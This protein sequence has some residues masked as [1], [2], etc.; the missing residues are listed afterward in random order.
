MRKVFAAVLFALTGA[1]FLLSGFALSNL[2]DDYKDSPDSM[3]IEAAT[4]PLGIAVVCLAGG[5]LALR[6]SQTR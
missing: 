4:I 6:N 3:F 2:F 1:C 5:V